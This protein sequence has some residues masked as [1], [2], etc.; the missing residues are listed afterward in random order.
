MR[1][2]QHGVRRAM[3]SLLRKTF[4]IVCVGMVSVSATVWAQEIPADIISLVPSVESQPATIEP[5]Q[6]LE[7]PKGAVVAHLQALD[8]V[9]AQTHQL[10]IPVGQKADFERLSIWVRGCWSA[11]PHERPEHAALLVLRENDPDKGPIERFSGWMFASSP[12]LSAL[13]HPVYD[14]R[15]I[16][17]GAK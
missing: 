8:K 9:T 16:G 4:H 3:I 2:I 14:I 5:T 13:E 15:V 7:K 1:F 6:G 17:C 12:A 11:P 10:H